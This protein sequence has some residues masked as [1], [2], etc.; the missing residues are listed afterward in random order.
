VTLDIQN[1][2][3]GGSYTILARGL[4]Q[5]SYAKNPKAKPANASVIDAAPVTLTVIPRQ[6][7]TVSV[8]P[9]GVSVKPGG[10]VEVAVR[11]SRQNN[12]T[13]E[14]RIELALTPDSKGVRAEP[15]VIPAGKDEGKLIIKADDDAPLGGHKG[16]IKAVAVVGGRTTITQEAKFQVQVAR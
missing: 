15:A 2:V 3:P 14:F 1:A 16:L 7:A 10:Q 4:A 12:Y 9:G 13:G 8:T 6:V 11:I 5:V